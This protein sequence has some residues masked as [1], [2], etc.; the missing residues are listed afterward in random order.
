M[1]VVF[2]AGDFVG[3]PS[4]VR[5]LVQLLEIL[6]DVVPFQIRYGIQ[7][8]LQIGSQ[9]DP[10]SLT[11]GTERSPCR[12]YFG[13][14]SNHRALVRDLSPAHVHIHREHLDPPA[15]PEYF[16]HPITVIWPGDHLEY[17]S[18]GKADREALAVNGLNRQGGALQP[19]SFAA[20]QGPLAYRE[21]AKLHN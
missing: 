7:I 17:R 5:Q 1:L 10:K 19:E 4:P 12:L 13:L 16:Q 20:K 9:P 18:S 6:F 2:F 15:F 8:N 3:Q 21:N 11:I 14:F